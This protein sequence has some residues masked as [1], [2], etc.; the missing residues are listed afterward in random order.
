MREFCEYADEF[1]SD[2]PSVY[3]NECGF[4]PESSNCMDCPYYKQVEVSNE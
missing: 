3:V 2:I 1:L 4:M